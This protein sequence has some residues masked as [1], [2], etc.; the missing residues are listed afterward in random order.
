MPHDRNGYSERIQRAVDYLGG[1]LDE[2]LGL[3]TLARVACFSPYHFHRIYRGLLGET[4]NE[5]VRRLRLQRAAIDL[6]DRELTVERAAR[7]AGYSSQAAFTRAFRAEYGAPPARYRGSGIDEQ[8]P[9]NY[10]VSIGHLPRLRVAMIAVRGDYRLTSRAFERLMTVAATTGMLTPGTRTIGIY[11]DDPESVA[12]AELRSA[13]CITVADEWTP[14]GE[15]TNAYIE[16]GRYAKIVHTGPYHEVE[17]RIRLALS[18]LAAPER[19]RAAGCAV[20]GGVPERSAAGAGEGS[21]DGRDDAT[22]DVS[23]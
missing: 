13:A 11:Y 19:R 1:H 22:K 18:E 7:R 12:E 16:G 6:L 15:L 5:T 20:P 14:S 9:A 21:Q 23:G 2:T 8:P 4:V 17:D 10:Q 3:E